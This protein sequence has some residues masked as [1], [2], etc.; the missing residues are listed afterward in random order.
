MD[1]NR[2]SFAKSVMRRVSRKISGACASGGTL[3]VRL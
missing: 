2:V 3:P 1:S